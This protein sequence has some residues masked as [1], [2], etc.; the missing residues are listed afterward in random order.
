MPDDRYAALQPP[1]KPEIIPPGEALLKISIDS[2]TFFA[3][4]ACSL[5]SIENDLAST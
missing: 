4:M 3:V 2:R 5:V 1:L